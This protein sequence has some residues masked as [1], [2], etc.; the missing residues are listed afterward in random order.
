[1]KPVGIFSLIIGLTVG[2][3]GGK[4]ETPQFDSGDS[5]GIDEGLGQ[6][7]DQKSQ[8]L[9]AVKLAW[10]EPVQSAKLGLAPNP[11]LDGKPLSK[12]ISS[13]LAGRDDGQLCSA[14][15]YRGEA[16]GGYAVD[17]AKN[18]ASPGFIP[19]A[20]YGPSNRSWLGPEGW[21]VGFVKN[22]TKPANLKAAVQA[23][24]NNGYK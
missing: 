1:M 17:V 15:H 2:C 12:I 8:P 11:K 9:N 24:I 19:S 16:A 13:E 14:C 5:P 7:A 20:P 4:P 23:W 6:S 18:Q 3:G 22:E 10:N 21:A